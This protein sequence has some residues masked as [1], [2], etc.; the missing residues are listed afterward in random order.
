MAD[1]VTIVSL[2]RQ[3]TP[4]IGR[5]NELETILSLIRGGQQLVTITGIG[6]IGKTRL[7][8][9]LALELEPEFANGALFLPLADIREADQ[10]PQEIGRLLGSSSGNIDIDGAVTLLGAEPRLLVLDNL[11]HLSGASNVVGTF[12]QRLPNLTLLCTSQIPLEIEGEQLFPLDPMMTPGEGDIVE[13]PA[14][15]L[16]VQ[17]AKAANPHQQFGETEL[18]VVAEICRMLDGIPLAIELAAGRTSIFSLPELQKQLDN[19]LDVLAGGKRSAPERQRTMRDAI[20]WSYDLLDD[21]E[22]RLFRY[23]SVYVHSISIDALRTTVSLLELIEDPL[24]ILDSMI[25]RRMLVPSTSPGGQRFRMLPIL[26]DF[27]LEQLCKEGDDFSARLSH[28]T[29]I[30]NLSEESRELLGSQSQVEIYPVLSADLGNFRSA[31]EWAAEYRPELTL[32]IITAIWRFLLARGMSMHFTT[33]CMN[34]LDNW[35]PKDPELHM[36]TLLALG[37][38]MSLGRHQREEGDAILRK[39][40]ELSISLGDT[41]NQGSFNNSLGVSA[42]QCRDYDSA[43]AHF[44]LARD[45]GETL[46]HLELQAGAG[47][48]LAT[49]EY[50]RG[51]YQSAIERQLQCLPLLKQMNNDLLVVL[52]YNNLG[53][54]HMKL[55]DLHTAREYLLIG[56]RDARVLDDVSTLRYILCSLGSVDIDLGDLKSARRY[57]EDCLSKMA[58]AGVPSFFLETCSAYARA[59]YV[60]EDFSE[61]SKIVLAGLDIPPDLPY[62]EDS[63]ICCGY[64]MIL[65]EKS[66]QHSTA[67][68]LAAAISQQITSFNLVTHDEIKRAIYESDKTTAD[69]PENRHLNLPEEG[70]LLSIDAIREIASRAVMIFQQELKAPKTDPIQFK[71]PAAI[72]NL[73][74]RE[75]EVLSMMAQ[76]RTNAEIA[77]EMYISLRTITTHASNIFA[78]LEVKNRS[79]AVAVAQQAGLLSNA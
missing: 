21:D 38:M 8:H 57:F 1:T 5:Q 25:A 35:T 24:D 2:P 44:E 33:I 69:K 62:L 48:N 70:T 79:S 65:A 75:Q 15:E 9:Q 10:I 14:I 61:L 40:L 74:T 27:G 77:E 17:R 29:H 7:A 28:A 50:S 51:N 26:R 46:G 72:P 31:T 47:S 43:A 13:G 12:L 71:S 22:K 49:V 42:R 59:L 16:F 4:L 20:S 11:E 52:A 58:N 41:R 66:N 54:F 34:A 45:I 73:T 3:L 6:G 18:P 55:G 68:T 56:L 37:N 78:K 30:T 32:R 53:N 64:A 23:L 39:G 63:L 76:G 60:D 36:K 67:S 19:R